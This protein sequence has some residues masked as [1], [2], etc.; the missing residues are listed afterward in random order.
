MCQVRKFIIEYLRFNQE[1]TDKFLTYLG[2]VQLD[3]IVMK[4]IE[5]NETSN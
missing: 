2:L 5:D 3:D 4:F 1:N